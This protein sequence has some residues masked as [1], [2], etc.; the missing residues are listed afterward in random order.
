MKNSDIHDP[1][2]RQ[3]VEAIGSGDLPALQALLDAYPRLVR[4]RLDLPEKGYF[5]SPYLIWF[6]ADNPIRNGKLP[7]N[8]VE[9]TRMLIGYCRKHA[10]ETYSFQSDYA[11]ALV[12][13]GRIPKECGVQIA[14]IDLLID[15]GANPGDGIGAIAHGNPEAAAH[16]IRRGGELTFVAAVG[17]DWEEDVRRLAATT[18]EDESKLALMVA[19]FRGNANMIRYLLARKVPVNDIPADCRGFHSHA[20]ALHQAVTSGSLESVKLLVGAGAD[21]SATD[22]VYHGTPLDWAEYMQ[23]EEGV[24][25]EMRE[26]Y[27][28]IEDYLKSLR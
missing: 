3:A 9:V 26:K 5:K 1:L 17:L 25:A 12:S 2:F 28:E 7:A 10:A 19:G 11:L 23:R 8:I 24:D 14:L 16:L 21:L 18:S 22:R 6:V 15:S 27:K 20:T 13:T 4:E